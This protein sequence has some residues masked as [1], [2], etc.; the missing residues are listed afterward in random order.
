VNDADEARLERAWQAFRDGE[1]EHALGELAEVSAD[2]PERWLQELAIRKETADWTRAEGAL[3]RAR[4]LLGA[5]DPDVRFATGDLALE[6]WDLT[7]ARAA[8]EGLDAG[9]FDA[10]RVERMALLLD[11]ERRFDEADAWL[12]RTGHRPPHVDAETFDRLLHRAIS[13]LPEPFHELLDEVAV[14]VDP[15][16]DAG[17]VRP[18]ETGH[19][20]DLMGLFVGHSRMERH[21]EMSG[22]LPP[23][24]FLFQRNIERACADE[25]QLVDEIRTTLYHELGHALGFDED[26]VD[27]LGLA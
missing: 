14:V 11:C 2:E 7:A 17:V 18:A 23:T 5:D 19:P 15:M 22:E 13:A 25:A 26:G 1:F 6:R 3:E 21:H 9:T 24:V 20:P 8:L 27:E 10:L 4:A 12:A 16:P